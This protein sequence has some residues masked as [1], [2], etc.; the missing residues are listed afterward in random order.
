MGKGPKHLLQ[1]IPQANICKLEEPVLFFF[2]AMDEP[3][4]T[5]KMWASK[6][7]GLFTLC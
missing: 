3:Q 5:K 1:V 4:I 6:L 7:C 2:Q